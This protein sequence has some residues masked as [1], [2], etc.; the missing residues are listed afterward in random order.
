M[1]FVVAMVAF[2]ALFTSWAIL[3]LPTRRK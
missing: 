3:P 2:L 1:E